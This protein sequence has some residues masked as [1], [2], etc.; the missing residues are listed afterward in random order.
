MRDAAV[1]LALMGAAAAVCLCM[2]RQG[3]GLM[4]DTSRFFD[5]AR[6]TAGQGWTNRD[7]PLYPLL[8]RVIPGDDLR[9]SARGINVVLYALLAGLAWAVLRRWWPD[10]F[11][12][13]VLATGLTV[14]SMP[15]LHVYA[16]AQTEVLFMPLQ[17]LAMAALV[18][19]ASR[20]R[21]GLLAASALCAVGAL[22]TRYAGIFLLLGAGLSLWVLHR[23]RWPLLIRRGLL[24]TGVVLAPLAA[25]L[26]WNRYR[27]G[28]TTG[29][30]FSV[31]FPGWDVLLN[32]VQHIAGLFVP[33][34]WIERAPFLAALGVLAL[35]AG[36]VF[37]AARRHRA[38]HPAV[39]LLA[40]YALAYV[41]FVLLSMTFVDQYTYL[42]LR[43]LPP[44]AL[45]MSLLILLLLRQGLDGGP[46][47]RAA[48]VALLLYAAAFTTAR[49]APFVRHAARQGLGAADARWRNS[50]LVRM[51]V[52]LSADYTLY[53]NAGE[54]LQLLF[55]MRGVEGLPYCI[56]PTSGAPRE[57]QY[58]AE[59]RDLRDAI[60][61]DR[62][63]MIVYYLKHDPKIW[64]HYLPRPEVLREETGAAVLFEH[65]DGV[66]LGREDARALKTLEAFRP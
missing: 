40:S 21:V 31:H 58:R 53:T 22:F 60:R 32:G 66:V 6:P 34:R 12:Y 2:S 3:V 28:N 35:F 63:L 45:S 33:W 7:A 5:A 15:L 56:D 49:G 38:G 57:D 8:L 20:P 42:D 65:P 11:G 29:R 30:D 23:D 10:R 25:V 26:L 13:A 16:Y 14:F 46:V 54:V 61:S 51:A 59:L 62:G 44:F 19:Y 48:S 41:A 64:T 9:E 39:P 24:Y 27:W 47:R 55:G 1:A 50:P 4:G 43:M 52:P 36:L 17:L 37:L 18:D